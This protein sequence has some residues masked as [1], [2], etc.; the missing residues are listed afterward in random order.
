MHC[1]FGPL[2]VVLSATKPSSVTA[3]TPR[4]VGATP[5]DPAAQ[6]GTPVVA[7]QPVTKYPDAQEAAVT[8]GAGNPVDCPN[9][10]RV[11]N[12]STSASLVVKFMVLPRNL[13]FA[14]HSRAGSQPCRLPN[15]PCEGLHIAFISRLASRD[16]HKSS[17]RSGCTGNGEA[18]SGVLA[19]FNDCLLSIHRAVA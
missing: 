19:K 17:Y 5:V 10:G 2:S 11:S 6:L 3:F 13:L 8:P 12:A 4:C 18:A 16:G 14:H 7:F 9:T 15:A 1:S